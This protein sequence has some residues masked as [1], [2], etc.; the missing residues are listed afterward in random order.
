MRTVIILIIIIVALVAA[1]D[2]GGVKGE[3]GAQGLQGEPGTQGE[4]GEQGNPGPKGDPGDPGEQGPRGI[5]GPEGKRGEQG[6]PGESVGEVPRWVLVDKNG[7]RVKALVSPVR[8]KELKRFGMPGHRCVYVE[9]LDDQFIGLK[10]D[11]DLGS[12]D[13]FC[14]DRTYR[15]WLSVPDVYFFDDQCSGDPYSVS[16]QLF[17]PVFVGDKRYYTSEDPNIT[18][19]S[20]YYK[21]DRDTESCIETENTEEYDFWSFKMIPT[22]VVALLR[23]EAPYTLEL[24]Y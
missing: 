15:V 3:K 18:N 23:D 24:E 2:R 16:G 22:W 13:S 4:Q 10:Y 21:W 17:D 20:S 12:L 1:C 11:L 9:Y 19:P 7:S 14:N 8:G 6:P 5:P